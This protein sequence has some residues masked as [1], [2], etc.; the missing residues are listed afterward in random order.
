MHILI[1][2]GKF[3]DD[4]IQNYEICNE[5]DFCLSRLIS[6]EKL[7]VAVSKQYVKS[8]PIQN[9]IFCFETIE[10]IQA[11]HKSILI[12]DDSIFAAVINEAINNLFN[13]GIIFKWLN[14]YRLEELVTTEEARMDDALIG[15][16]VL[17]GAMLIMSCIAFYC[18]IV[19]FKKYREE[20]PNNFWKYAEMLI[21]G[22]RHLFVLDQNFV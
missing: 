8:I 1:V 17:I 14:E 2:S 4:Q 12:R 9:Q 22:K 10:R 13:S 3:S 21:D 16:I 19:T 6:D 5:I 20:N 15:I 18:E 11:Y 7:A